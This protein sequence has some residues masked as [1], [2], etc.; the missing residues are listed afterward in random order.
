MIYIPSIIGALLST[1]SV[2]LSWC[3][4]LISWRSCGISFFLMCTS[5]NYIINNSLNIKLNKNNYHVVEFLLSIC[6]WL[7]SVVSVFLSSVPFSISFNN[8]FSDIFQSCY[9][10]SNDWSKWNYRIHTPT[11]TNLA[12]E[13]SNHRVSSCLKGEIL[14]LKDDSFGEIHLISLISKRWPISIIVLLGMQ[15]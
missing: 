15:S 4:C 11:T 12:L 5:S 10:K 6:G 9:N 14:S 13:S 7:L 8:G 2:C 1:V 3:S